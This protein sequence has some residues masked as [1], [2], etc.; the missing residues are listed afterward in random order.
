MK[1]LQWIF[2]PAV[3]FAIVGSFIFLFASA[4]TQLANCDSVLIPTLEQFSSDYRLVQAY[5]FEN[6]E[7]LYEHMRKFERGETGVDVLTEAFFG[8]YKSTNSKAEFVERIRT[9]VTKEG[10]S[11]NVGASQSFTRRF[12]TKEQLEA[13][14]KCNE[15]NSSGGSLLLAVSEVSKNG[16]VLMA[17]WRPQRGVGNGDLKMRVINGSINKKSEVSVRMSG[18]TEMKWFVENKQGKN[19]TTI[20][21]NIVGSTDSVLVDYTLKPIQPPMPVQLNLLDFC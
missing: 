14:T 4:Q 21:A 6:A 11:L 20:T 16:F 19:P 13:W 7:F 18:F 17:A 9:K 12:L 5:T 1:K 2:L 8:D 15:T 3:L 10:F